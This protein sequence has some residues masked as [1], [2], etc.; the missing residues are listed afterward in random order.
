M[1][2][3]TAKYDGK[4]LIPDHPVELP[5]DVSLRLAVSADNGHV[6]GSSLLGLLGLGRDAWQEIDPI[7]YQ[8]REREGWQ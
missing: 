7:E 3:F 1:V 5:R 6:E 2:W 8:R 4:V